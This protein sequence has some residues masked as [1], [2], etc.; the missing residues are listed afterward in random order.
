MLSVTQ[1][2]RLGQWPVDPAKHPAPDEHRVVAGLAASPQQPR[3]FGG[4]AKREDRR[5]R[6]PH[7]LAL[8]GNGHVGDLLVQRPALVEAGFKAMTVRGQRA[9][10]RH[11]LPRLLGADVQPHDQV[12]LHRFAHALGEHAATAGGDRLAIGLV[13]QRAHNLLLVQPER[14]L[15]VAL[16]Q[17]ADR[18]P[19]LALDDAIGVDHVQPQLR[20][21]LHRLRLA[22]SHEADEDDRWR[23]RGRSLRVAYR[24]QPIRSR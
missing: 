10:S 17:L 21:G 9:L 7:P 22:G 4:G 2:P 23:A 18:G 24:R 13:E 3:A 11:P 14:R 12:S 16:E 20:R 6:P 5:Q 15:A 1:K 8:R 19:Q